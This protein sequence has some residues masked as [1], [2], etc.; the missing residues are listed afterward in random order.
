MIC[1]FSRYDKTKGN[2]VVSYLCDSRRKGREDCPPVVVA[3]NPKLTEQLI[4]GLS[5]ERKYTSGVLSF[6]PGEQITAEMEQEII[7]RFEQVAFAGL[8]PDRYN[9]LWVRHEHAGHHELHFLTPRIELSTG[10]SL[11][12]R[13]PGKGHQK[14]FDD[15]RSE[16]NARFGLADPD[17]PMRK[18]AVSIPDYEEKVSAEMLRSGLKTSPNARELIN[19]ILL[20][21]AKENLVKNRADVLTSLKKLGLTIT[22]ETKTSITVIDPSNEKKKIRLTGEIYERGFA[23]DEAFARSQAEAERR[24][25]ECGADRYRKLRSVVDAH[26]ERRARQ[27]QERYRSREARDIE[28]AGECFKK[29]SNLTIDSNVDGC[30]S[31]SDFC[32]RNLRDDSL[33]ATHDVS[34][35]SESRVDKTRIEH[36]NQEVA[37]STETGMGRPPNG[38]GRSTNQQF[39]VRPNR[40]ESQNSERTRQGVS[41]GYLAQASQGIE[42]DRVGKSL[43]RSVGKDFEAVCRT[44]DSFTS[45]VRQYEKEL[46]ESQQTIQRRFEKARGSFDRTQDSQGRKPVFDEFTAR[47]HGFC[48]RLRKRTKT[49]CKQIDQVLSRLAAQEKK[50]ERQSYFYPRRSSQNKGMER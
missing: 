38:T 16:I 43:P 21:Q 20:Q 36:G 42:D 4:D 3:G 28:R 7:S 29:S 9:I 23:L 5:F 22:R 31:L 11:N 34:R 46:R 25:R 1:G 13:P 33:L 39:V 35:N 8:E 44:T 12:I 19:T 49:I 14:V 50:L 30:R 27:N 41:S 15:F 26:I 40:P 10:K 32:R 18:R 6:A 45:N 37:R 2:R 24:D 48:E 47:V 17:D